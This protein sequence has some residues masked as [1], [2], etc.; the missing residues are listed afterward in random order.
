MAIWILTVPHCALVKLRW[1]HRD[2]S[3][4]DEGDKG[5]HFDETKFKRDL[6]NNRMDCEESTQK[7][8]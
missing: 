4:I 8:I 6:C 7:I 5:G 2:L 3:S 1:A